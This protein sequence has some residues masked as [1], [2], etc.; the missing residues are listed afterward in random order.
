MVHP[1]DMRDDYE[2]FERGDSW[3]YWLP[4]DTMAGPYLSKEA[5]EQAISSGK[6]EVH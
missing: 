1:S 3:W 6:H 4:N 2:P 5:C